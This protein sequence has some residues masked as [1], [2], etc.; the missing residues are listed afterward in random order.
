MSKTSIYEVSFNLAKLI[1]Q[2]HSA[3]KSKN[4]VIAHQLLK[5]ATSVGAN[6]AEAQVSASR[7]EFTHKLSIALKEANET[8]FW[9]RLLDEGNLIGSSGLIEL[10]DVAVSCKRLLMRIIKTTKSNNS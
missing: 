3:I 8:L 10:N 5:S 4:E 1:V 7:R 6:V 2:K 9:I